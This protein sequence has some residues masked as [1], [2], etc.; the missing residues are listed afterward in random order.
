MDALLDGVTLGSGAMAA[1]FA[2]KGARAL[3][4]AAML[5]GAPLGATAESCRARGNEL[6]VA[7]AAIEAWLDRS[8][9][10]SVSV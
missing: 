1:A 6:L 5:A 8:A 4:V 10:A 7:Q 9:Y 2:P 3:V